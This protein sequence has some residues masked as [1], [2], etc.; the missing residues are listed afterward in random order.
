MFMLCFFLKKMVN[1]MLSELDICFLLKI[2]TL[3]K[4]LSKFEIHSLKPWI[5]RIYFLE[6]EAPL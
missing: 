2:C 4:N 5:L 1:E 3:E 6:I